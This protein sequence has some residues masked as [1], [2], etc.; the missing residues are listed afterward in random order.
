MFVRVCVRVCV[1]A[2]VRACIR[3]YTL[4]ALIT[5]ALIVEILGS[6]A[7]LRPAEKRLAE[8]GSKNFAKN[9]IF[10]EYFVFAKFQ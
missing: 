9:S 5:P 10:G 8:K 2:C 3:T 6:L 1:Y 7:K 4:L